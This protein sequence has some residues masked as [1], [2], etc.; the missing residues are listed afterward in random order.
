MMT[1][2][3]A[4]QRTP[5]PKVS[6]LTPVL[7][8]AAH[9]R[10]AVAMMCAQEFDGDLELLFIDGRSTDR[11]VDILRELKRGDPRIWILDNPEQRTPQGLNI[12][13]RHATGDYIARMDAHTLYPKDYLA[14]G[15]RRLAGG[16]VCWA[17][18]PQVP[19]GVGR[20]SELTARALGSR[21]GVGGASF[22][23]SLTTEIE[24]DS[25][26]TGV[27]R[28]STLERHNGWD[29]GW[30]VNQDGELAGR[31]R[32]DG[33]RI[34][35]VPEM[36]ASYIPRDSLRA[37]ARQY[38]RYGQYRVKTS[39]RHPS[40]MRRSHVLAPALASS[41]LCSALPLGPLS[42]LSRAGSAS[43]LAAV[44][45]TSAKLAAGRPRD[46]PLLALVFATMHLAWGFGFLAGC[47]KFG[48]PLRALAQLVGTARSAPR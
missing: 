4:S 9:I 6:V 15:V 48:P 25:G 12:G 28:A 41:L 45:V 14:R 42:R 19:R 36:A 7:N 35:C 22:R 5:R 38:W 1:P 26:F 23:G 29:E 10:E 33:G 40:S 39:G 44:T 2:P 17:S 27:W 11:T 46:A 31:I 24:V 3:D 20:W 21:L 18:G 43:Y 16:D 13:L 34:V 32:Q 8:E 30:P 37:L 47:A